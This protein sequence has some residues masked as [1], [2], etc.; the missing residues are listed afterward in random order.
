MSGLNELVY[1]RARATVDAIEAKKIRVG[2]ELGAGGGTILGLEHPAW[3]SRHGRSD[4]FALRDGETWASI[5]LG[6]S[7]CSAASMFWC[8][9][10]RTVRLPGLEP[11]YYNTNGIIADAVAPPS[12]PGLFRVRKLVQAARGMLIAYPNVYSDDHR[13]VG[14]V[15]VIS[16]VTIEHGTVVALRVIDCHGPNGNTNAVGERDG[17]FFVRHADVRV[18]ELFDAHPDLDPALGA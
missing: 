7:D 9:L 13:R 3:P 12:K 4:A 6:W 15:A 1:A 16:S 18:C 5:P 17:M 11:F 14:H 2:Y 10:K 8:G